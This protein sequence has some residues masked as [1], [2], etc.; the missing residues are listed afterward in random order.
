MIISDMEESIQ[1]N[2]SEMQFLKKL[3]SEDEQT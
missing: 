2:N 1:L 3:S